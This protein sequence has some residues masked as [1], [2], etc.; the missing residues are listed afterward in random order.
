M[1]VA[2]L[3]DIHT[4]LMA[5]AEPE[6]LFARWSV[7]IA[8]PVHSPRQS[9]HAGIFSARPY[10]RISPFGSERRSFISRHAEAEC[11]ARS[12]QG[13][14]IVDAASFDIIISFCLQS[15]DKT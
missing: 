11:L 7:S 1:Q 4:R 12:H 14:A 15:L 8:R 13:R 6:S 9:V 2:L 10:A 3:P 5:T